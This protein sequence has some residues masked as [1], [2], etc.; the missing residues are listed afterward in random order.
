MDTGVQGSARTPPT[1]VLIAIAAALAITAA[2]ATQLGGGERASG[3]TGKARASKSV[4]LVQ[5]T[6]GMSGANEKRRLVVRCPGRLV[7]LGGGMTS[8]PPP[9]GDGE[10]VYP[11]SYERVG[12]QHGWHVTAVL[13]DPSGG[14]TT[15]RSVTLQVKCAPKQKHVTPP[16]TTVYVNPGHQRTIQATCPGRRQL[17]AGGFQRTDFLA[18]GGDYV[19]ESRAVGPKTWQVSGSAF[20]EFGGELTAIGYCRRSKKPLLM[21]VSAT[22]PVAPGQLGTAT[23][24]P[25]PG[26]RKLVS[27]GFGSTPP[28]NVLLTNGVFN[29]NN[30]WSAS[31]FNF[32]G[33]SPATVSAY[34][35]C[36]KA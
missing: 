29:S 7:P 18:R 3:A 13:F 34:G 31:G 27:G 6:F 12:V 25:C 15:P 4:T 30:S 28:G 32:F 22:A 1:R 17:F 10:G 2:A 24:P 11:H 23:T 5:R 33:N 8:N 14:S 19:S 35:Y 16:H 26:G 20:G 21:E 36:L 9:S